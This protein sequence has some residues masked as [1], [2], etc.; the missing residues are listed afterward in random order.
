SIGDFAHCATSGDFERHS[1]GV[2]VVIGAVHQADREI[3]DREAD[4]V[5]ALRLL[6]H[7]LFHSRNIFAGNIAALDLVVE[8]DPLAAFAW[9]DDDLGTAELA[10]TAGLLLVRVIDLDLTGERF[11]IGHLRCTHIGFDLKFALHAVDENVE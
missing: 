11:T 2:D 9:S 8:D 4:Q 5:T 1:A 7:A 10:R 6:A 3:D